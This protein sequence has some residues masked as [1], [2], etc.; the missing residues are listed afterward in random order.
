MAQE[1]GSQ[2][3][4]T[5]WCLACW[6]QDF[7]MYWELSLKGLSSIKPRPKDCSVVFV[8]SKQS[9]PKLEWAITSENLPL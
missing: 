7:L 1:H 9:S 2:N 4:A 3:A 5:D 6:L 8:A